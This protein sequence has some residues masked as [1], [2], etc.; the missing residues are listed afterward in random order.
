[1]NWKQLLLGKTKKTMV[2]NVIAV[3]LLLYVIVIMFFT[4][5]FFF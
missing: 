5:L 2:L 1:M 3:L 4:H